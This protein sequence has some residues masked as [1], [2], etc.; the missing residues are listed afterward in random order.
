M[1]ELLDLHKEFHLGNKFTLRFAEN[2]AELLPDKYRVIVKYDLQETPVF[3]D[4]LLNLIVATSRE[5]HAIP[6][7]FFRN[8]IYAILQN[9]FMLDKWGYPIHN[10]LAY[11]MPIGTFVDFEDMPEIKP[12]PERK[13]DFSFIGQIPHTG[14][15]DAFKR[16]LDNLIKETGDKFNY[17]VEYTDGFNQGLGKKEYLD[18]LN[19]SKI[20]LCPSG[21]YSQETFRFFEIIKMGAFPMIESLPRLWYYET[22]PFFKSKWHELDK[23]LSQALNF[24]GHTSCRD[25]LFSLATYNQS[26]LNESAL[27]NHM[28][29]QLRARDS[30]DPSKLATSLEEIRSIAKEYA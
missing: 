5:T 22:A 18:L 4:D 1:A 15:R 13:Y 8:D 27:A 21:A 14:T 16:N 17:F 26:V 12:I 23:R 19:D 10:P 30:N 28:V 20:V 29:S 24:L 11:P 7:D 6:Q 3:D 25:M 2:L 9:Y